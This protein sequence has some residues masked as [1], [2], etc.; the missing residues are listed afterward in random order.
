M[1]FLI[2]DYAKIVVYAAMPRL[3]FEGA[4]VELPGLF[5]ISFLEGKIPECKVDFR[6]V[7]GVLQGPIQIFGSRFQFSSFIPGKTRSF[8]EIQPTPSTIR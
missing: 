2:S 3:E 7:R 6:I 1:T 5:A 4:T 8:T